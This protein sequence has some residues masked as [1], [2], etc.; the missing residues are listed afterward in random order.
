MYNPEVFILTKRKELA[1]KHKKLIDGLNCSATIFSKLDEAINAI[2]NN[3][4]EIILVSDTIDDILS[5][6][7][8][9][10]R[11]LTYNFR[12]VIIAISKSDAMDDKLKTDSIKL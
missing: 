6:F 3:E 4:P 10:I 7:I 11:I 9:K 8:R 1:I 12:P 2:K 5:D